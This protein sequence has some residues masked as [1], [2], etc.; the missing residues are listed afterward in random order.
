VK[1]AP[2]HTHKAVD[3]LA[4]MLVDAQFPLDEMEREK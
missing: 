4:D 1:C 2:E 3:V